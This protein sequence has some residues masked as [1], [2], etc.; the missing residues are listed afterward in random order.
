MTSPWLEVALIEEGTTEFP[1]AA[2]NP[3]IVEYLESTNIGAPY[4]ENDETP[5]CSAFVNWCMEQVGIFG[6]G[7]AA[8]S[9]WR[10]WGKELEYGEEGC[11]VVMSR[12]GGNHVGFYLEEVD[13]GVLVLGGNQGDQV[14]RAWFD[15]DRITNFRWPDES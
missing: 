10:E 12:P 13:E 1:G 7:S 15:W 14:S 6:T 8:A 5:W 11:I 9:S 2:D 3:R 4:N